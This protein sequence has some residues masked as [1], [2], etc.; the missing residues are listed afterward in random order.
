MFPGKS[1]GAFWL[2]LACA[3]ATSRAGDPSPASGLKDPAK[4]EIAMELV[5]AAE[6]SSLD[7]KAQYAYVEYNVEGNEAENRGYTAGIIGFTSKTH[8]MLELVQYYDKIAPGNVLS[9]YLPALRKVDGT[10]SQAGLGKPFERDWKIAG[11]E[12]NFRQA[13][14]HERD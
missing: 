3:A 4:K 9:P 5:S 10:S 2:V 14:D 12:P 7:W 6:N 13:Q 1:T 11:E 8:D